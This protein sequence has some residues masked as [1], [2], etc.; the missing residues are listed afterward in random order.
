MLLIYILYAFFIVFLILTLDILYFPTFVSIC[1]F[2]YLFHYETL[3]ILYSYSNPF[4]VILNICIYLSIGLFWSYIKWNIYVQQN[5][6]KLK[7]NVKNIYGYQYDDY[8]DDKTKDMQFYSE[9]KDELKLK[10]ISTSELVD[11]ARELLNKNIYNIYFWSIYWPFS[12]LN[13]ILKEKLYNLY[14]YLFKKQ[15][16]NVFLHVVT[17]TIKIDKK[18]PKELD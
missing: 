3:Y 13:T 1:I 18:T 8:S 10:R 6:K 14:K 17:N 9:N 11:Y 16:Y 2:L 4:I 12:I 15:L 5:K 7:K